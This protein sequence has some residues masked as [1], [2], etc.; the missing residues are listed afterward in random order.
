MTDQDE[1]RPVDVRLI[2]K[3]DVKDG[4]DSPP[5][6]Y[7]KERSEYADPANYKY[8]V[9]NRA[10]TRAAIS[11]FSKPKN[12]REYTKDQQRAVWKRIL[13]AAKKFGVSVSSDSGPPCC[14]G[15]NPS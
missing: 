4:N 15:L 9:N 11:Y 1:Y 2:V 12:F 13:A 8:P 7:P 3:S 6:G 10:R 5:K 14:H